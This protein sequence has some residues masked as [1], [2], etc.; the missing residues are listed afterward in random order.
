MVRIEKS[1]RTTVVE[2]FCEDLNEEAQN[3]ILKAHGVKTPEEANWDVF[4]V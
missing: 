2:I 3:A 4:P 1:G